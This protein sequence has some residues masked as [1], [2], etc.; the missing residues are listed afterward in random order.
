MLGTFSPRQDPYTYETEEETVPSSMFARGW[1][2]VRTKVRLN[3]LTLV[4][5][6]FYLCF[7]IYNFLNFL[8]SVSG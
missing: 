4:F 6:F 1:Y 5:F 2:C 7:F 8:V 3:S